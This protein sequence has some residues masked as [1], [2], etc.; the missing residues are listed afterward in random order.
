ML[1]QPHGLWD[2]PPPGGGV[3]LPVSPPASVMSLKEEVGWMEECQTEWKTH[4]EMLRKV[5]CQPSLPQD[6]PRVVTRKWANRSLCCL[7]GDSCRAL[8]PHGTDSPARAEGGPSSRHPHQEGPHSWQEQREVRQQHKQSAPS[9]VSEYACSD[10][11]HRKGRLP[12][13]RA[14][15]SL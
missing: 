10:E 7:K 8:R 13:P 15:S 1:A 4:G 2:T 5:Q 14:G 11:S 6:A 3:R 12:L 9:R